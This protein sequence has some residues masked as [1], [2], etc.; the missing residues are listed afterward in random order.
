MA[1]I[2]KAPSLLQFHLLV[3]VLVLVLTVFPGGTG[4]AKAAA[5]V[6]DAATPS[7]GP[8]PLPA[9]PRGMEPEG[10][11]FSDNGDGTVT[12]YQTGLIWL[13]HANCLGEKTLSEALAETARLATG[14]VCGDVVLRDGSNP[15]DWRLPTIREA[16]SLP[17]IKY[18]NPALT[19]T[20][21]TGKWTE[22]DPFV[23]VIP[24]YFWT[25]T[26]RGDSTAWYMYLHNGVPGIADV[27]QKCMVWP[28][29]GRLS[30]LWDVSP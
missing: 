16:M 24:L 14:R 6:S 22:N 13:K 25:S 11:R 2:G 17:A 21:G 23:S 5:P 18:F 10:P 27:N 29:K 7:H 15:G 9:T 28:V 8:L 1:F 12:D 20:K 19:N 3:M 4:P 26:R 30:Y